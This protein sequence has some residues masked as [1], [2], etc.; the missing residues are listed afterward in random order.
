MSLIILL[1]LVFLSPSIKNEPILCLFELLLYIFLH[2]V[3]WKSNRVEQ[4]DSWGCKVT[5]ILY[6]HL[7]LSRHSNQ[8]TIPND[9]KRKWKLFAFDRKQTWF[10]FPSSFYS[11]LL[12]FQ[13]MNSLLLLV[14][15][16]FDCLYQQIILTDYSR[17][18]QKLTDIFTG[19]SSLLSNYS[20][21]DGYYAFLRLFLSAVLH[22]EAILYKEKLLVKQSIYYFEK[23]F[24]LDLCFD[25]F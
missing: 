3:L 13:I 24:A 17:S 25:W 18:V 23:V 7:W 16:L 20:Y 2:S 1:S 19:V 12:Y 11:A 10:S 5:S 4:D 15:L 14:L 8:W 6:E 9:G 22:Y 21:F